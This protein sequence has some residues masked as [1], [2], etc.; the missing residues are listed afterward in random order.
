MDR[1]SSIDRRKLKSFLYNKPELY[2]NHNLFFV[3]TFTL[4]TNADF[5]S[6]YYEKPAAFSPMPVTDQAIMY[7]KRGMNFMA[8][9]GQERPRPLVV[10]YTYDIPPTP[11]TPMK[12]NLQVFDGKL[13]SPSNNA[14]NT[15]EGGPDTVPFDVYNTFGAKGKGEFDFKYG[16]NAPEVVGYPGIKE[17][18]VVIIKE[19]KK[20]CMP[21]YRLEGG[22]CVPE[23]T[24]DVACVPGWVKKNGICVK[25]PTE[26]AHGVREKEEG[27][28]GASEKPKR[29]I[30]IEVMRKYFQELLTGKK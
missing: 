1:S 17:K 18:S 20:K 3:F 29:L 10:G 9:E 24:G 28:A 21:G 8:M 26:F 23:D 4:H 2:N 30:T 14:G 15:K 19:G 13:N 22:E 12:E 25:G 16:L 27:T 5:R 7:G 6:S 11:K